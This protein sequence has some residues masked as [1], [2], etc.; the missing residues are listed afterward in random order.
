MAIPLDVEVPCTDGVGGH[1]LALV[2]NLVTRVDEFALNPQTGEMTF[3]VLKEG[4]L[5]KHEVPVPVDQIRN[6]SDNFRTRKDTRCHVQEH[7][8]PP[9]RW[10]WCWPC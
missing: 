9:Y 6:L 1:S 4:G 3:L 7:C 5:L 8:A 2:V 10:P